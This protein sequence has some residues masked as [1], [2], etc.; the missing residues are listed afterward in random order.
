MGDITMGGQIGRSMTMGTSFTRRSALQMGGAA[1]LMMAADRAVGQTMPASSGGL[2]LPG[3]FKDGKYALPDLPYGYDALKPVL[4]D[5]ILHLHHDKHHAA[6][7]AGLNAALDKLQ[8]ARQSGDLA[9][10]RALSRDMAFNGSGHVLHTI[11]WHSMKPGG[12]KIE[13]DFAKAVS[14][15]FGSVEAMTKQLAQASKDVEA[16]GWGILAY[17]PVAGKLLVMQAERHEDLTIW[18]VVPLLVCD[19]WEHAYYLQYQN[20]RPEWVDNFLKI[21]NWG[22]AAERYMAARA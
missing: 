10:V 2:A 4:S 7:V 20:R 14:D 15:S 22:F 13:G 11:F 1:V 12:A 3:A 21:A 19:V 16:S 18:G 9:A 17:E 8:A 6:Y 5:E